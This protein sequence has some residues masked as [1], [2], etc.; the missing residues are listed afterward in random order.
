VRVILQG[1]ASGRPIDKLAGRIPAARLVVL[2]GASGRLLSV[3]SLEAAL[4]DVSEYNLKSGTGAT[5]QQTSAY[6]NPGRREHTKKNYDDLNVFTIDIKPSDMSLWMKTRGI[7]SI[8][9]TVV[10]VVFT[11]DEF[12]CTM[13]SIWR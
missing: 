1:R 8:R 7:S 2:P 5:P 10:K 12:K 3:L 11:T 9:D 4:C 6:P 13:D